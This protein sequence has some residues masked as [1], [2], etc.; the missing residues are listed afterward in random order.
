M[1]GDSD[2]YR[3]QVDQRTPLNVALCAIWYRL[4]QITGFSSSG[5][6]G[7]S[8]SFTPV[9]VTPHFVVTT[10]TYSIPVGAINSSVFINSGTYTLNGV[11]QPN[12]SWTEPNKLG[13][14]V[15][16]VVTGGSANIY[17]GT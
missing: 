11:A 17:F 2:I 4:W 3:G 15:A 5:G 6:G 13:S 16:V 8:V 10:T 7:I 1:P 9:V 12:T 14:A